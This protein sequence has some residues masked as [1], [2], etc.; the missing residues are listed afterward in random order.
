MADFDVFKR[1]WHSQSGVSS[2]RFDQIGDAVREG[3]TRLQRTIFRRD[4]VE[5][6]ASVVVVVFFAIGF[7]AARNWV[8][9]SGFAVVVLCGIIIPSVLWWARRR[10]LKS[11]ASSSF[12]DLIDVEIDYLRRQ[13]LLL[14]TVA[15]WYL[16]PLFI[17]L[18]LIMVGLTD[19]SRGTTFDVIFFAVF[20]TICIALFIWGWWINQSARKAHLQPLLDYYVEM[21]TAIESGEEFSRLP[22]PVAF[23]ATSREPISGRSRSLWILLTVT[24]AVLTLTLGVATMRYFDRRSG[25]FVASTSPV[26]ALLIIAISGLW[27]R[28]SA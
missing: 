26:L 23:D 7:H 10:P 5:T 8:A 24:C 28:R 15:W 2:E 9:R 11:V 1:A 13:T 20:L 22:P 3:T 17:G 4:M 14:K 12:R 19:F 6:A 18:C 27:R 25:L 16:M 21:R